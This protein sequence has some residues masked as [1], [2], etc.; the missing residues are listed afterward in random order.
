MPNNARCYNGGATA[1]DG[2]PGI[3]HVVWNLQGRT[4]SP[5]PHAQCPIPHA[6]YPIPSLLQ[7]GMLN[8]ANIFL[9]IGENC[10]YPSPMFQYSVALNF[11][12]F[13]L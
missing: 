5:M 4:G 6:Q 1:V 2:F 7:V 11:E 13:P 8:L 9:M 10:P 12:R 3:K